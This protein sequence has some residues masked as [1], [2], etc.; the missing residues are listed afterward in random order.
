MV[1]TVA[2]PLGIPSTLQV[3]A[4]LVSPETVAVKE[5]E[6]E[7]LRVTVPDGVSETPA[8]VDVCTVTEA[9]AVLVRSATHVAVTTSLPLVAGAV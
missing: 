8:T 9:V 7:R 2:L 6:P 4:V 5:V 1:P 3:T